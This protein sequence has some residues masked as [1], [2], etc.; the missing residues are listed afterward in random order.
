MRSAVWR[1]RSEERGVRSEDCGVQNGE[2]GVRSRESQ[3]GADD[4]GGAFGC[5]CGGKCGGGG[6]MEMRGVVVVWWSYYP[7]SNAY[8][9][10][11]LPPTVY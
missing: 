3:V 11:H 10:Y 1:V 5:G 4:G 8:S 2:W 6:Y 9:T 7:L